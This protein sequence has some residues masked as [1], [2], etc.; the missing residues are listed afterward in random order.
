LIKESNF[1]R[2]E[3]RHELQTNLL[4]D[5]MGR[6]FQSMKSP[7]KSGARLGWVFAIL[8]VVTIVVWQIYASTTRSEHAKL[9]VRLDNAVHDLRGGTTGLETVATEGEGTFA[10]R[11][12]RFDQA[13]MKFDEAQSPFSA[14]Q[15]A[16]GAKS[17]E[18]ARK[19][20][21][22]LIDQCAD[23]PV[24]AQEALM[25][26]A[27][28]DES[29]IGITTPEDPEK[30]LDQAIASY[31]MLARRFPESA[32]GK[33]ARAKISELEG[34]KSQVA[35]FYSELGQAVGI[36]NVPAPPPPAKPELRP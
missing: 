26:V 35:K 12:A 15:R 16:E 4:A 8:V 2:A 18:E 17:L 3:H 13:R 11:A 25:G 7:R 24:L 22:D 32:L 19:I 31:R 21:K 28:A 36:G 9:W 33:E 1:M 30:D 34:R 5:R 27:K 10:A 29:L 14:F 23:Q 6:L 20:Y